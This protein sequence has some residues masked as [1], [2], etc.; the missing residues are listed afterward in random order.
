[1]GLDAAKAAEYSFLASI[2]IIGAVLLKLTLSS[3][4]RAYYMHHA[5]TLTLSNF[6]A[7]V[8]GLFAVSFL[9][10]YLSKHGLALFGWYRIALA[11]VLGAAILIQLI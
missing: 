4:G 10:N 1:M 9:I 3:D 8:S 5:L 2:P 11:A 7:F 6:V